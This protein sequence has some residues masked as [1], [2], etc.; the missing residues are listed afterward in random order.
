MVMVYQGGEVASEDSPKLVEAD[1]LVEDGVIK[2]VAPGLKVPQGAEVVGTQ[3]T[4]PGSY[5]PRPQCPGERQAWLGDVA[6]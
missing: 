3:Q 4:C 5:P 1:V 6:R 2:G